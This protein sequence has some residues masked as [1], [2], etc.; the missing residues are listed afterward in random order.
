MESSYVLTEDLS[1]GRVHKRYPTESGYAVHEADNL[2][3]A[4]DFRVVNEANAFR[5]AADRWCK[6]CFPDGPELHDVEQ[7]TDSGPDAEDD[8]AVGQVD[9]VA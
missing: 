1:S 6:R 2:D 7:D 9:P 8:P 3:D 4:G 5:I